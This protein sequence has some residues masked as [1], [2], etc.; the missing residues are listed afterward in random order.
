M[1]QI[2]GYNSFAPA[3]KKE[4]PHPYY[5]W[6]R[7][8]HPVYYNDKLEISLLSRYADVEAAARTTE[9]ISSAQGI[10]PARAPVAMMITKDPPDHT[11]LPRLISQAFTPTMV[12][13]LAPR[14]REV[15]DELLGMALPR[16]AFNLLLASSTLQHD[17]AAR[18]GPIG[19]GPDLSLPR[20]RHDVFR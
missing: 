20:R 13:Q 1:T 3:V 7:E 18:G 10:G 8:R 15:V 14:I 2:T 17:H 11:R 19:R 6:L 16:G 12:E 5:A 4:D 9:A